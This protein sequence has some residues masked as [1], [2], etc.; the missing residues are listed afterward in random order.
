[1]SKIQITFLIVIVTAVAVIFFLS[2]SDQNDQTTYYPQEDQMSLVT[3]STSAGDIHLELDAENAPITVANFLQL[4]KDGYYNGTIFHRIIDGFMVQGGGLDE[5][6]APKPTGTE[7]IQ[8]EANNGLK[9][10]RGTL[11]M[12]RT[13]DPHSAT[14]QFFVNHKDNDFL[15]HT[16]ETSQGWGYAVFGSVIDGMD[17]VDQIALSTTSTVGGYADAPLE[18]TIINSVTVSE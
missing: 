11:A 5:N 2:P 4:A 10:D 18:P 13:M 1:M 9:N 3:I 17:I 14:G 15:N 16:S 8:N 12:A 7:P 6:M